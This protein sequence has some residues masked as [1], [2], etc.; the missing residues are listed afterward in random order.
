MDLAIHLYH[1]CMLVGLKTQ[2]FE[3]GFQ[4]ASWKRYRYS[5]R[6]NY[7]NANL[8]KWWRHVNVYYVFSL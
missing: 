1:N 6:V 5:L 3:N 2:T 7:E 4:N 8:W